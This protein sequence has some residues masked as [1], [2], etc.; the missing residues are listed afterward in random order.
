[1]W[2]EDEVTTSTNHGWGSSHHVCWLPHQVGGVLPHWQ[3]DKSNNC[4]AVTWLTMYFVT[5]VSQKLLLPIAVQTYFQLWCKKCVHQLVC[6]NWIQLCTTLRRTGWWRILIGPY[7][8]CLIKQLSNL[9]WTGTNTSTMFCLHTGQNLANQQGNLHSSCI[10]VA[11]A[12]EHCIAEHL[13]SV[14][15]FRIMKSAKFPYMALHLVGW[16]YVRLCTSACRPQ[17]INSFCL[18]YSRLPCPRH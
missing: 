5:M 14:F 6:T 11:G 10:M 9:V 18:H 1:M 2:S 3:P 8:L 15:T 13:S 12:Y 7:E 4:K 16:F 17:C